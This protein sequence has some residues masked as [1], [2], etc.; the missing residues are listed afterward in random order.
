MIVAFERGTRL[1]GRRPILEQA[2]DAHDRP[3][4]T[5]RLDPWDYGEPSPR[6]RRSTGR[7]DAADDVPTPS[8]PAQLRLSAPGRGWQRQQCWGLLLE[9]R[10]TPVLCG[11]P[12]AF[13]SHAPP[14]STNNLLLYG[15]RVPGI[16][17]AIATRID[18][19]WLVAAD[20]SVRPGRIVRLTIAHQPQIVIVAASR[21]GRRALTGMVT[22]RDGR[23]VGALLV[24]G[25]RAFPRCGDS[26]CFLA[27]PSAGAPPMTARCRALMATARRA[28][29]LS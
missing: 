22:S 16:V 20:R 10:S 13:D 27:A 12:A 17:V 4:A 15:T 25:G 1:P 6:C 18:E 8:G 24:A 19:A 29:G 7:L 9:R 21:R 11:Y 26:P 23:I 28:T 5:E 3:L 2:L 14:P